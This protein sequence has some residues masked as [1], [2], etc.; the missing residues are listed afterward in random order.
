M[1][2]GSWQLPLFVSPNGA[3]EEEQRW[4]NE[5]WVQFSFGISLCCALYVF[6][7]LTLY[8]SYILRVW[9]LTSICVD[10]P[11]RKL[12]PKAIMFW[13]ETELLICEFPKIGIDCILTELTISSI[14]NPSTKKS[15][16]LP[17]KIT[18]IGFKVV[19]C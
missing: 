13:N 19:K 2:N 8:R 1:I 12:W 14:A 7:I 5:F 3:C 9:S 4:N 17:P 10:D 6:F 15:Q 11:R 16:V 18:E